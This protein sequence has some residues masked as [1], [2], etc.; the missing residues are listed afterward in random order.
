MLIN[1]TY[2][3]FKDKTFIYVCVRVHFRRNTP[4]YGLSLYPDNSKFQAFWIKIPY[5]YIVPAVP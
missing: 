2:L 1:P 4:N 5:L 3:Q